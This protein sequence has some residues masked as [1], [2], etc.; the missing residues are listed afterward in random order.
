VLGVPGPSSSYSFV[1]VATILRAPL[2]YS[3]YI[4]KRTAE[5][6]KPEFYTLFFTL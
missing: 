3:L 2:Q 4:A 5:R 6:I 1:S